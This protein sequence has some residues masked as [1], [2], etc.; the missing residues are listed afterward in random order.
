MVLQAGQTADITVD[1]SERDALDQ[2]L[3]RLASA[4]DEFERS[5]LESLLDKAGG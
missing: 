5:Q 3:R 2:V 1:K 4:L